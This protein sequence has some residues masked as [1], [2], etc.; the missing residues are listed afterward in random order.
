M[1]NRDKKIQKILRFFAQ[2]ILKKYQPKVI[3]VTGS[4]GKTTTKEMIATVLEDNFSVW[5]S[6]KNYNN[7]IGIPLAIIG[8]SGEKKNIGQWLLVVVRAVSL[9]IFSQKYPEILVLELAA[10]KKGDIKYFCDFIPIDIGILTNVGMSHLENFKTKKAIFKEKK[11]LLKKARELVIY[12]GDNISK[13][14]VENNLNVKKISYGINDK[15]V[16]AKI[17]EIGYHYNGAN[18]LAGMIFKFNYKNNFLSGKVRK[19]VGKPYLYGELVALIVAD[20]FKINLIKAL[21]SLENFSA[22]PGHMSLLPGI[23]NTNIIDDTYNSAPASV[24]QALKVVTQ[25]NA[26][27]KIV[28]LG[29][30]L[31]LGIEEER[32]HKD[33]GKRVSRIENVIFVAIGNRMKLARD[34]FEDNFIKKRY[35]EEKR[36]Y[37]METSE[38]AKLLV[39]NIMK[40]GD[41]VLV[42]GSQ[43]MR[44]EKIVEEIMAEPNKKKKLLVRQNK[45]WQNKS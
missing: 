23:K 31:E 3:A 11:Y 22:I 42:K 1:K 37:W 33:V 24:K 16:S 40:E 4:V 6:E 39:Q 25:I 10:D 13:F 36:L 18:V 15:D 29:D 20:H 27:R 28:V 34:G 44:M 30:M 9:I 43:G 14:K 17:V 5:K 8:A 35:K 45:D 38:E 21:Q 41:L 12:N 2:L 32:A 26:R 7:E 19:L